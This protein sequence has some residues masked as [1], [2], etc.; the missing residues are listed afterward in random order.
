MEQELTEFGKSKF[1]K[2]G[3]LSWCK[4][5]YREYY[6]EIS[7]RINP[8]RKRIR[9]KHSKTGNGVDTIYLATGEQVTV[10][11][12]DYELVNQY[13]WSDDSYGYALGCVDGKMI[14][15]HRLIMH[16]PEDK[17]I[18]HINGRKLDNRRFNL[19]LCSTSENGRHRTKMPSNNTSGFLGVSWVKQNNKWL[20]RIKVSGK[21]KHLGLFDDIEDAVKSRK[22]AEIKYFGEFK[23]LV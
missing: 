9:S 10:N 19:R 6:L 4:L 23:P 3:L 7:N 12:E 20:S 18:D 22:A 21:S 15:M 14:R 1:A 13:R 17:Y 2:D 5:C 16:A 8:N 11:K